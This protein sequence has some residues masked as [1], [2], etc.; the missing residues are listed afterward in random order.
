MT[1]TIDRL[2]YEDF[3]GVKNMADHK[4]TS[5]GEE[6]VTMISPYALSAD[7]SEDHDAIDNW[8]NVN[9]GVTQI[10]A[11][12]VESDES[13]KIGVSRDSTFRA[14]NGDQYRAPLSRHYWGGSIKTNTTT[15]NSYFTTSDFG[16]GKTSDGFLHVLEPMTK[17]EHGHA[18]INDVGSG[19]MMQ[20]GVG[21][22]LQFDN[23]PAFTWVPLIGCTNRRAV[24]GTAV[25]VSHP[26]QTMYYQADS[27]IS[28]QWGVAD[29][30]LNWGSVS[31]SWADWFR[32]SVSV[33]WSLPGGISN[34]VANHYGQNWT[35]NE[36]PQWS[37]NT[38]YLIYCHDG[39]GKGMLATCPGMI[40]KDDLSVLNK[41]NAMP[42]GFMASNAAHGV[43]G[44]DGLIRWQAP[45][46]LTNWLTA[47]AANGG[48]ANTR[49]SRLWDEYTGENTTR[50]R[51]MWQQGV[52]DQSSD[53]YLNNHF[54]SWRVINMHQT[55]NNRSYPKSN[56]TNLDGVGGYGDG[57]IKELF[58][59][60]RN[61]FM[62]GL[63]VAFGDMGNNADL[64]SSTTLY[65]NRHNVT[66]NSN[67][68]HVDSTGMLNRIVDTVYYN[69]NRT[70]QFFTGKIG[71]LNFTNVAGWCN[72][73]TH[74]QS[75]KY[76]FPH[77]YV[78]GWVFQPTVAG[79][80]QI[81]RFAIAS[82]N[83]SNSLSNKRLHETGGNGFAHNDTYNLTYYAPVADETF[84]FPKLDGQRA[85][86]DPAEGASDDPNRFE[87][88]TGAWN[89][90]TSLLD[91]DSDTSVTCLSSGEANALY[92]KLS[93]PSN[94][95]GITSSST[96]NTFTMQIAGISIPAV[97]N[98]TL[99][100]ALTDSSKTVM[101]SSTDSQSVNFGG[102]TTGTGSTFPTEGS[103][104]ISMTP[105]S[106]TTVAYSAVSAGYMKLWLD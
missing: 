76:A 18:S 50:N 26:D 64:S 59:P 90:V 16:D 65:I 34:S 20:A 29:W 74:N 32:G 105:D 89:N 58:N 28:E 95:T 101:L 92:V 71:Q 78:C 72:S 81:N 73:T 51:N 84:L 55:R 15:N 39:N 23:L 61:M 5:S 17:T 85:S 6:S 98:N 79:G 1:Q 96:V 19:E 88:T 63:L 41:T 53:S 9:T 2:I 70:Q 31:D 14:P 52:D 83:K 77:S 93:Q 8:Y 69:T 102:L 24:D 100:V 43:S 80:G 99:R 25:S 22:D 30:S 7:F 11:C 103:Y 48:A 40:G 36:Q 56:N 3:N 42:D 68:T 35:D 86:I 54:G 104:L 47:D 67:R 12:T 21:V 46:T 57:Y 87:H 91:D 10:Y 94:T 66:H 60:S 82:Y 49:L 44:H 97:S 38:M 27:S 33:G 13:V 106:S 45:S 75:S 62:D 37:F 4:T